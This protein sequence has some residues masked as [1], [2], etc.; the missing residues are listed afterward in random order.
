MKGI[1]ITA[2]SVM[3]DAVE[4][5]I[6]VRILLPVFGLSFDNPVMRFVY[7][8]TE[9]VLAPIRGVINSIFKRPVML[10]FSPVIAWFLIDYVIV[11]MLVR[12]ID[13]IMI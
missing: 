9:P 1:L 6:M 8:V 2:V 5:V 3:G 13:F 4:L 7:S 11:P 12:F 10:D